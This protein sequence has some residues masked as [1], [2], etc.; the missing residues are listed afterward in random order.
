[1][2]KTID[3]VFA[4]RAAKRLGRLPAFWE[5]PH[6]ELLAITSVVLG[7]EHWRSFVAHAAKHPADPLDEAL[8]ACALPWS[9]W[10][11]HELCG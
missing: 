1:M 11:R 8:D 10:T 3:L 4:K 9:V 7:F 6:A 5:P 2:R